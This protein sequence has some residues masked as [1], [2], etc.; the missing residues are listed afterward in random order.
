MSVEAP[1]KPSPL[2]PKSSGR[3]RVAAGLLDPKQL[4]RALPE[5]PRKLDPRTLWRNP[6]MFVTEVG[7][8]LTTGLAIAEPSGFGWLITVWLWLTVI[9]ANLAGAVAESRGRAQADTSRRTKQ[10]SVARRV[11]G[12]TEGTPTSATRGGDP[13]RPAR[14]AIP[15]LKRVQATHP[16][17]VGP[18]TGRRA[19]AVRGHQ[20][21]R[22][23]RPVHSGDLT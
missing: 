1:V 2:P 6:V 8:L 23:S 5:A 20:A 13:A 11:V 14:R 16:Q 12:W 9:F 15:A 17:P 3:R 7:A 19:R 21:D 10:Q 4:W 22:P 18:R